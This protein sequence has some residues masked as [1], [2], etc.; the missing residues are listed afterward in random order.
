MAAESHL[1][2]GMGHCTHRMGGS[3][4]TD[5]MPQAEWWGAFPTSGSPGL[6]WYPELTTWDIWGWQWAKK[7]ALGQ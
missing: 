6:S 4:P 7:G 3:I 2:L 1:K 5:G